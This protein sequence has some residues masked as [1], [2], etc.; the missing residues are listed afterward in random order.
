MDSPDLLL[1]PKRVPSFEEAKKTA[2]GRVE[3]GSVFDDVSAQ[4]DMTKFKNK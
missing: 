2:E 1:M 4:F 3:W